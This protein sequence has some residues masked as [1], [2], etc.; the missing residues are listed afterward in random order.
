MNI[1]NSKKLL[2]RA[3]KVIPSASQTFSKGPTQ[4][5][6]NISPSF[7]ERGDGAWVW[8]VDG[9]KYL[10]YVMALGS[11]TL[12]YGNKEII[13]VV[14]EQMIKGANFSM[15]NSLE[16]DVAEKICDLVPCA[17]MVRFGKNG[18]DA[19]TAMVRAARAYTKKERVAVC[20]YHGWHDWYI[21]S[22]TRN[23]GV[24][25][26]VQGLTHTFEFND[27]DSLEK[28]LVKYKNEF[29]LILIEPL[30]FTYPDKGFLEG[31]RD[32]ADIHDVLLGFD[33]VVSGFRVAPGSAQALL[34]V[35]PDIAAFG[36]GMANGLPLSCVTGRRDIMQI[37]DS[38]FFST[39]FGGETIALAA[40]KR[41][42]EIVADGKM[43]GDIAN[44][45]ECIKSRVQDIINKENLSEYME[46]LGHGSHWGLVLKPSSSEEGL[47]WRS[48]LIQECTKRGY[49]FFGS[50]NP[51]PAH[52]DQVLNFAESV[53]TEVLS[54]FADR[55]RARDF[56]K[57]LEGSVIKPIFRI[58][59]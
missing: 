5:V 21:G 25:E 44:H 47:Y 4:W 7:L 16:I 45:G 50:H 48:Y 57:S 30:S 1:K 41:F 36:K 58:H 38:I 6:E 29:A 39:T 12:G 46:C 55:L 35:I 15:M 37:F 27:L 13:D 56:N 53:Y 17:E 14:N 52:D 33:E 11:V 40:A 28:L 22:T 8:D 23:D 43:L 2:E 24:P 59:K 9:N 34:G 26:C 18:S 3:Y 31:I 20:G 32:L 54:L 51:T 42:L 19:T 10:D 49:L